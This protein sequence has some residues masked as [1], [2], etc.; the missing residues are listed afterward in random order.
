M[1]VHIKKSSLCR[2][3]EH[4]RESTIREAARPLFRKL[5]G[6]ALAILLGFAMAYGNRALA[7][8]C[9]QHPAGL[10]GWWDADAVSG[11]TAADIEGGYDG[12]MVNG[13][14][15]VPGMVGNAFS[16]NGSN[17]QHIQLPIDSGD[18]LTTNQ[19]TLDAWAFPTKIT[20]YSYFQ[21]I[22]EN[23][24]S[25]NPGVGR[26]MGLGFMGGVPFSSGGIN[27][28]N[29]FR[30]L[31]FFH[32]PSGLPAGQFAVTADTTP[33]QWH[34]LASTY[35]GAELCLYVDGVQRVCAAASGNL[36]DNNKKFLIAGNGATTTYGSNVYFQGEID[37]VELFDRALTPSQIRAIYNA[38][39]AGK[40]KFE[41][42]IANTFVSGPR[43]IVDGLLVDVEG[44]ITGSSDAGPIEVGRIDS[45]FY[46]FTI[47]INNDGDDDQ[48]DGFIVS[49]A[50]PDTY[51][52]DPLCGDTTSCDLVGGGTFVDRDGDSYADGIINETPAKCI[53]S[54]SST[55][56]SIKKGGEGLEPEFV[57]ISLAPGLNSGESCRVRVFVKTDENFSK[58]G[59]SFE[60]GKCRE[61]D[62]GIY[63][64]ITLNEGAKLFDPGTG[65][66][67]LG[68]VGS[69]QL[70]PN[71]CP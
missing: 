43:E 3:P 21:A 12:T 59:S 68:P 41:I 19:F 16:Y 15:I 27:Y 13:V 47:E 42:F 50:I 58:K 71:N 4:K 52:L 17:Y 39:A 67:L 53:V 30:A 10:V 66:R 69:L 5:I 40:C 23:D 18:V 28:P 11:T 22:I 25:Q 8:N 9:V 26:G 35:D 38:G 57:T 33:N 6:A 1:Y 31:A 48:F 65:D 60:P 36:N 24:D 45:Q 34:H 7:Q 49:D 14:G 29:P 37:E 54:T 46:E 2:S 61:L 70:T 44:L 55:D 51:D 62:V 56:S 63:D 20:P 32:D 64:T